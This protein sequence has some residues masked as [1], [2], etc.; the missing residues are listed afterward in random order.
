MK[1]FN[2]ISIRVID[3]ST[4][5]LSYQGTVIDVNQLT[6]IRLRNVLNQFINGVL[7]SEEEDVPGVVSK[8]R[9]L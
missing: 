5:Q 6:A 9:P 4:L 2:G 3:P 1:E 7:D 8:E